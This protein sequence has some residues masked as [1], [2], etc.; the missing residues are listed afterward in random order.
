MI[1]NK[2]QIGLVELKSQMKELKL[3]KRNEMVIYIYQQNGWSFE[4]IDETNTVTKNVRTQTT[5]PICL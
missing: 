4:F 5:Q 1:Q 3:P 2:K